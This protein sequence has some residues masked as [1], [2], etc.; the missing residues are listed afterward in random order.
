RLASEFAPDEIQLLY[1]IALHGRNDLHLA[2]DE[3]AGFTMTLLR[4]LT[5][6][7]GL[8]S[9][10]AGGAKV[11]PPAT[12][13]RVTAP[14]SVAPSRRTEGAAIPRKPEAAAAPS[15]ER[16]GQPK[17]VEAFDGNWTALVARLKIAGFVKE[18]A[19]QSELVSADAGHFKLRVPIR[20]LIE[21]G[22]VERLRAAVSDALGSPIRLSAEVGAP[23]GPT[24]ASIAEQ[25]RSDRQRKAEEAIYADPFV[26]ELTDTFGASVDRSSIRPHNGTGNDVESKT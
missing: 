7:P 20:T 21:A 23:V 25:N 6:A 13:T 9:E 17:T 2:P 24:V 1:Q 16:T 22:T 5:F 12:A 11:G 3:Y 18:L 19:Q 8:N 10:G 26:R 14:A 4:M 15:A